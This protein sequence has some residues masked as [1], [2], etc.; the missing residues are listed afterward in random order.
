MGSKKLFTAAD[1]RNALAV[2]CREAGSRS[3]FARLA[4]IHHADVSRVLNGAAPTPV[5][6]R[7]L[8][9]ERASLYQT[10]SKE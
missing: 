4:G 10:R 5:I 6:L 2:A 7:A 3:A 8:D 9:L 1:V